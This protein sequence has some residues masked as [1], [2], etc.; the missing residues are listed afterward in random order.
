MN[1]VFTYINR[2]TR[3]FSGKI[4]Q[5][6]FAIFSC[7]DSAGNV[8]VEMCKVSKT[9]KI[10]RKFFWAHFERDESDVYK[11]EK[12]FK[13]F[14]GKKNFVCEK[15]RNKKTG[16]EFEKNLNKALDLYYDWSGKIEE[17]L[18]YILQKMSARKSSY[19]IFI[20]G[21][22]GHAIP[23]IYLAKRVMAS[24]DFAH[25]IAVIIEPESHDLKS[26]V[27]YEK[28]ISYLDKTKI[29]ETHIV[30]PSK[31]INNKFEE[32]DNQSVLS[33]L[34]NLQRNSPDNLGHIC[35][36]KWWRLVTKTT[37]NPL[38]T[39]WFRT[40]HHEEVP[41]EALATTINALNNNGSIDEQSV[42][43]FSGDLKSEEI[44]DAFAKLSSQKRQKL[45]PEVRQLLIKI[46]RRENV[47]IGRLFPASLKKFADCTEFT[48]LEYLMSRPQEMEGNEYYA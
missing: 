4:R 41:F 21:S 1:V 18:P 12:L 39:R 3:R 38:Y 24:Y 5:S 25:T 40:R 14:A 46:R 47:V 31:S 26:K 35:S 7:G 6:P 27:I 32:Q 48:E 20:I 10:R 34:S 19:G 22:G 2:A 15:L 17:R 44:R 13:K 8:Q 42:Y 29:F 43:T 37:I 30:L 23:S 9:I 28:M 33:L 36:G 11:R 16:L 45:V